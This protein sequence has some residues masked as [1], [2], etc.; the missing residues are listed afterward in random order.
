VALKDDSYLTAESI[1]VRDLPHEVRP[2]CPKVCRCYVVRITEERVVWRCSQC[3][4]YTERRLAGP[5][6]FLF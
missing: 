4:H 3:L 2:K 1:R 6:S 5:Q